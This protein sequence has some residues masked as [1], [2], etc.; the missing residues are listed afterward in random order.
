[1]GMGMGMEGGM[2]MGGAPV[3]SG[4]KEDYSDQPVN[5]ELTNESLSKILQYIVL[6]TGVKMKIDSTAVVINHL[7][8]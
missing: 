6:T 8:T 2:G 7:I 5:M 1:M 3:A 4:R